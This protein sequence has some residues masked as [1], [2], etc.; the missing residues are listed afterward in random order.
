MSL[1]GLTLTYMFSLFIQL[2]YAESVG[3]PCRLNRPHTSHSYPDV[4]SSRRGSDTSLLPYV[5]SDKRAGPVGKQWHAGSP[6][7]PNI[8]RGNRGPRASSEPY[9]ARYRAPVGHPPGSWSLPWGE[10]RAGPGFIQ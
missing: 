3:R 2:S 9:G 7:G 8:A 10:R 1:P 6:L 5:A 4:G